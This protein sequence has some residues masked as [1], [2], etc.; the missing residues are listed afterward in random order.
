M[1]FSVNCELSPLF[2]LHIELIHWVV[3]DFPV[4]LILIGMLCTWFIKHKQHPRTKQNGKY[5]RTETPCVSYRED[6]IVR[7]MH[8][9][10]S[11]IEKTA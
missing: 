11:A 7:H 10:V 3:I 1:C 4:K 8:L 6:C 5:V 2:P 9:H